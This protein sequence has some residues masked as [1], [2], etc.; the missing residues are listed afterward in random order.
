M[1]HLKGK[2]Y[3]T[4]CYRLAVRPATNEDQTTH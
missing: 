4:V 2:K 3:Q 1:W